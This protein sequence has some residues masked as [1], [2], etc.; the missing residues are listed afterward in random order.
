MHATENRTRTRSSAPGCGRGRGVRARFRFHLALAGLTWASGCGLLDG[1]ERFV[2]AV[3]SIVAPSTVPATA[4]FTVRFVGMVG[5]NGCY[6]LL[7][8]PNARTPGLLQI[9]FIGEKVDR[10]CTQEPVALDY[11]LDVSPPFTNPFTI[12]VTQPSGPPLERTV[13]VE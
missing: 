6:S 3:D 5:P 11:T 12:R 10:V 13:T 4:A 1:P 2:V 7:E 9:Q 8:A